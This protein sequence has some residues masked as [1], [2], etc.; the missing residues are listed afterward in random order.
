M[1][2]VIIAV[3]LAVALATPVHAQVHVD[4]GIHFP[5]PPPL[6]VVPETPQVQYVPPAPAMPADPANVFFYNGQYWAFVNGGWYVG[7]DTTARGSSLLPSSS[8]ARSCSCQRGTT[9]PRLV[10]GASGKPAN[11][12]AGVRSMGVSGPTSASGEGTNTSERTNK[13]RIGGTA[14]GETDR[15]TS[16]VVSTSAGARASRNRVHSLL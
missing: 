5:A 9:M 8:L 10:T 2:I 7:P 15:L 3:L 12:H 1:R 4:I 6:V 14:T 11:L 16:A 13:A